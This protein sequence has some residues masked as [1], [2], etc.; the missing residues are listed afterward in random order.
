[1]IHQPD[2]SER[3]IQHGRVGTA[4][5]APRPHGKV[6]LTRLVNC[7]E[8]ASKGVVCHR[9]DNAARRS[10]RI[11][12]PC[13][14]RLSACIGNE[15]QSIELCALWHKCCQTSP[16]SPLRRPAHLPRHTESKAPH[17]CAHRDWEACKRI[18]EVWDGVI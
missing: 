10:R 16:P 6:A 1:M 4:C 13:D 18:A 9:D 11:C 3:N 5:V 17:R 15:V 7:R 2:G 14:G 8:E 12:A